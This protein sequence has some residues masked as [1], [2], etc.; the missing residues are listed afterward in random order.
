ME[1]KKYSAWLRYL[2][3]TSQLLV[4]IGLAVYGGI[5][6]DEKFNLAPLLTVTLPLL[7]LGITFYKLIKETGK[8]NKDNGSK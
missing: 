1:T 4:M 8:K 3:I 7:V 5:W 2:G 6:L